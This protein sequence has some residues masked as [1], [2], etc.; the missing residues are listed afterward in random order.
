MNE[1]WKPIVGYEEIY[2]V[3]SLGRIRSLK[4][5]Y[6]LKNQY[7]TTSLKETK[8]LIRKQRTTQF[9]YKSIGLSKNGTENKFQVHRLVAQAFIS[10]PEN[11]PCINHKN[12]NKLDN[13]VEN[14]EWCTY[15]ENEKHAYKNNLHKKHMKGRF[16][17]L[18]PSSKK[19]NQYDENGNFIKLWFSI[20]DI[21]RELGLN[22][23]NI[24]ACCN[25]KYGHKTVGGF[26]WRFA[27]E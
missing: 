6:Y 13:R 24:S 15:S 16:G 9:G 22:C 12:G 1:I 5:K 26:I 14:L 4:R 17:L 20:S 11:K 21:T 23:A 19:V 3:S 27:D 8:E 25:G 10:N 7:G 18:N 2:E